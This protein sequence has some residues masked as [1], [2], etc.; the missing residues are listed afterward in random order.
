MRHCVD[1]LTTH[2]Q[3]VLRAVLVDDS[4]ERCLLWHSGPAQRYDTFFFLEHQLVLLLLQA[5]LWGLLVK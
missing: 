3:P 1:L 2:G 4:V 5:I